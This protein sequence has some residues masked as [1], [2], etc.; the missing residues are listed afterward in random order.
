MI[1]QPQRVLLRSATLYVR[2]SLSRAL[3]RDRKPQTIFVFNDALMWT[4]LD[5]RSP[6]TPDRELSRDCAV[7]LQGSHVVGHGGD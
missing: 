1:L 7:P 3:L 6:P 2:S 4:S 5:V